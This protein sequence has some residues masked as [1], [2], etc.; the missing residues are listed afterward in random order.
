M[1]LEIVCCMSA[2]DTQVYNHVTPLALHADVSKVWIVRGRRSA[3][4]EVPKAEYVLARGGW[5]PLRLAH[6]LWLLLKLGRRPEVRAYASFNPFPYGTL[7][8]IAARLRNKPVHLGFIGS[9][10]EVHVKGPLRP[11]LLP[12]VRRADYVTV[13]GEAM[14]R[15][16]VAAGVSE[17]RCD[18][19][20]HGI[21]LDRYPVAGEGP[22]PYDFI[23]VGRLIQLKRV[24]VILRAFARFSSA[25]P[26]GRLA[27]VGRGPLEEELKSLA[28][29][30]GCVDR[31]DFLGHVDNVAP[32][33]AQA[34]SIVIASESEGF[35]FTLIEGCCSGL[36]P[37]TTPVG[38]IPEH[39]TDGVNGLVVPPGD[40]EKLVGAMSR[41][42]GDE[43]FYR[44]LRTEALKFRERFSFEKTTQIWDRWIARLASSG[45]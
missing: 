6:T 13:T 36:V 29:G 32:S 15:E 42:C 38:T 5:L 24:D 9:D 31:V 7:A 37:I 33:L 45:R 12:I 22:K 21:D 10:W 8:F 11:L 34:R 39:I 20:P 30:L 14:R 26:Q 2:Q 41:L 28:A 18:I 44:R 43:A 19:L 25:H 16:A 27:I 23:F 40:V 3:F 1:S 35:P 17:E 4:G